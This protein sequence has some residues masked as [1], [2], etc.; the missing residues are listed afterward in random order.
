MCVGFIFYLFGTVLQDDVDIFRVLE[1]VVESNHVEV[2]QVA[3]Q[4]NFPGDLK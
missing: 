3:M 1:A 4:F 2:N